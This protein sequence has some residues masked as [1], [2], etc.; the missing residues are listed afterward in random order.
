MIPKEMKYN[1]YYDDVRGDV[2]ECWQYQSYP[3]CHQFKLHVK[4]L[5]PESGPMHQ[6]AMPGYNKQ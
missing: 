5:N 4:N 1:L 6:L 3:I 2:L